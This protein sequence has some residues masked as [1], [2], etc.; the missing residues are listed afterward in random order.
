MEFDNYTNEAK[1]ESHHVYY[2]P[3]KP[4]KE[5]YYPEGLTRGLV[6]WGNIE[7][8]TYEGWTKVAE[9]LDVFPMPIPR[10]P[11]NRPSPEVF[12]RDSEFKF[13]EWYQRSMMKGGL[14]CH[15]MLPHNC[16]IDRSQFRNNGSKVIT[17]VTRKK[18][19]RQTIPV[20]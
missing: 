19:K 7:D 10:G 4:E 2:Y 3:E 11:L 1:I 16:Y 8:K 9:G 17:V 12:R 15:I 6:Y 20:G 14:I 18:T 5:N 13:R